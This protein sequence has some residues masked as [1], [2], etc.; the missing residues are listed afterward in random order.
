MTRAKTRR[1][2]TGAGELELELLGPPHAQLRRIARHWRMGA[3]A[4]SPQSGQPHGL[5]FQ[6]G[7]EE[8]WGFVLQSLPTDEE[9]AL[10]SFH[11]YRLL[12]ARAL[13][14][15]LARGHGGVMAPCPYFREHPGDELEAGVALFVGPDAA[16]RRER[17][18]P[19]EDRYDARLGAGAT[20]MVRDMVDALSA[21]AAAADVPF[22]PFLCTSLEPRLRIGTIAMTLLVEGPRVVAISCAPEDDDPVWESVVASGF[23]RLEH[24]PLVPVALP[25]WPAE[26]LT[27]DPGPPAPEDDDTGAS[28]PS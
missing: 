28:A 23:E 16:S 6:I 24:V 17:R 5:V 1:I 10:V 11:L 2:Q 4:S 27:Q 7:E 15:Y 14:G 18:G 12:I 9:Q 25:G 13:P 20:A 26:D 22:G 21:A 19:G 3:V 8:T